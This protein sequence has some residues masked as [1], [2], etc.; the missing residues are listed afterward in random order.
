ML[1]PLTLRLGGEQRHLQALLD[2][3]AQA[4]CI[5][6]ATAV[7]LELPSLPDK[8]TPLITPGGKALTS[9]ANHRLV[10]S[11]EDSLGERQEHAVE[12]VSCEFELPGVDV[13]LGYPAMHLMAMTV[14]YAASTWYY[15]CS[16][17]TALSLDSF[18]RVTLEEPYIYMLQALP[19]AAENSRMVATIGE[20]LEEQTI[21]PELSDFADVFSKDAAGILPE[22]HSLEH[23]IELQPDAQP[24]WSSVYALSEKELEVLREYLTSAQE[25]GWI[26]PSTSPAGAAVMFVPKKGGGLRLCVDYRGLNQVT[27]KDRTPLPLISETLDR[28]RRAKVFTKFDLKDAY[29]RLRIRSG[30]EWKTAFR[31][32]YGHFEYCVMPF[33]LCNAP[34]TFQ[35]YIN[36]A[37]RGLVD[38]LCVVYL[39]DILVYSEDPKDHT[40]AVRQVLQRLREYKLYVNLQKCKFR[41]DRV[42]FLGF[43]IN[44]N[45]VE[46]EKS[47]IDTIAK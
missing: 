33:G 31:T 7:E 40:Q 27:V 24:P 43:V 18:R 12:L 23:K 32:R 28:M 22:H 46:M 15:P 6:R 39:D 3:G 16:V 30:D 34:A 35:A 47:R 20:G 17:V 42:E 1:V 45:G 8:P 41:T 14:D 5:Q 38:I 10:I 13:I 37:L 2:S 19:V 21:P 36:H 29:H 44:T 4:N 26:R 11:A 25:K 9:Y